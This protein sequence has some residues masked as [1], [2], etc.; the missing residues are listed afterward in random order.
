[1]AFAALRLRALRIRIIDSA[2][3]AGIPNRDVGIVIYNILLIG[4]A[5]GDLRD[6]QI[7]VG[8]CEKDLIDQGVNLTHGVG[9]AVDA[10]HEQ[11]NVG[12]VLVEHRCQVA[13]RVRGV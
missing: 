1:V 4:G 6:D 13:E 2:R 7:G 11:N 10:D 8:F 5:E 3:R 9:D 12:S